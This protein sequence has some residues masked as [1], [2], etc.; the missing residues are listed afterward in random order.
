[1]KEE[2]SNAYTASVQVSPEKF[3]SL[4]EEAGEVYSLAGEE[5]THPI[6]K[7][8]RTLLYKGVIFVEVND[9]KETK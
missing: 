6:K 1:M 7:G 4:L 2:N 8:N 5:T 9:K 3:R